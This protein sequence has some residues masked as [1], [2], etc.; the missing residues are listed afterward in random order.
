MNLKATIFC[1]LIAYICMC[2]TAGAANDILLL[3]DSWINGRT[4]LAEPLVDYYRLNGGLAGGGYCGLVGSNGSADT[5]MVFYGGNSGW[6]IRDKV[7][8]AIGVDV[9]D[10]TGTTVNQEL[11]FLLRSDV[12]EIELYYRAQPGG[13]SFAVYGNS[14]LLVTVN[15]NSDESVNEVHRLDWSS[16]SSSAWIKLVV[17]DPRESGVRLAGLN[18]RA[19]SGAVRI[20]EM[21]TGGITAGGFV[22]VDR[23]A[24]IDSV[25][26]L[27]PEIV[28]VLLGTNDHA[29]NV[30]PSSFKS[31][32]ETLVER[33]RAARPYVEILLI[34]P[35]DN[36]LEGKDY[37]L[38]DYRDVLAEVALDAQ[39]GFVDLHAQLGDYEDAA[40]AGLY[41]D[42]V[43][44]NAEGGLL[45]RDAVLSM[46][47]V[48]DRGEIN[49][50]KLW[51]HDEFL[52]STDLS[53]EVNTEEV[54]LRWRQF[55]GVSYTLKESVGLE[56]W[57]PV[58]LPV[59]RGNVEQCTVLDRSDSNFWKLEA[60][61]P[62]LWNQ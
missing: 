4:R 34:S 23:S 33:I 28:C 11:R 58:T 6:Q 61:Y 43:H 9:T 5:D 51:D 7:A 24:W 42:S 56:A 53:C 39:I 52:A 55:P 21:G 8:D 60:S 27:R 20:H 1:R 31:S 16:R 45:I 19:Y 47:N 14:D 32:I 40:A 13:G 44:P 10:V 30:S 36:G 48:T 18:F 22:S 2:A 59:T 3:G 17:T 41:S 12:D 35:G 37:D 25:R 57:A 49:V 15:T 38:S 26:E 29:S 46:L 62:L 54:L 50:I